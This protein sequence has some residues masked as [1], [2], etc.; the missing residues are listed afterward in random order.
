MQPTWKGLIRVALSAEGLTPTTEQI[1]AYQREHLGRQGG[2]DCILE[3]L[4]LPSPGLNRW[5]FYHEHSTL[6][7][8]RDRATYTSYV[9]PG[10]AEHLRKRIAEHQPRAV[11]F[12]GAGYKRW[13]QEIAGLHFR[14]SSVRKVSI[15]SNK[16][17]L[18]VI[19]QHPSA[20]GSSN[21]Y[22]DAVGDLIAVSLGRV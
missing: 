19:M 7:H 6:S 4:P 21:K 15:A 2:L 11:V 14:P 18:F 9:A 5:L 1:R 3:L 13:W 8:L 10:R 12:Y 16:N 17:T 20:R 22:I